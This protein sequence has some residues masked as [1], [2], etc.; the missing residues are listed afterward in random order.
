[1]PHKP[2]KVSVVPRDYEV[3]KGGWE[4]SNVVGAAGKNKNFNIFYPS[5]VK[6]FR[7]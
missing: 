3:A 5:F 1:M 7:H 4:L 6:S 2:S